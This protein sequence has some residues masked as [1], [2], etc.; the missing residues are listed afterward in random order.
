MGQPKEYECFE[1]NAGYTQ[2]MAKIDK[3]YAP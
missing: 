2:S 1:T 3:T